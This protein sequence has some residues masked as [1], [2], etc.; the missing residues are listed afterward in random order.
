MT[1]GTDFEIAIRRLQKDGYP[2]AGKK[3]I[4]EM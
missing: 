1:G 2:G 4:F 3:L